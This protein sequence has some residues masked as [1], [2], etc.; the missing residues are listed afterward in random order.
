MKKYL[1]YIEKKI[2]NK[3][4]IEKIK[5]LD[6]SSKHAKHKFFDINKYHLAL[7]IQSK[8]LVSLGKINSHRR[9]MKLLDEE[10]KTKIHALEIIIK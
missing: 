9:I 8:Y 3:L 5:I 7:E 1:E 10:L 6:N 2:T 4:K